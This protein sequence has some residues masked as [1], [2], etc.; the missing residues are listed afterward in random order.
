MSRPPVNE[1]EEMIYT[2]LFFAWIAAAI[3][4]GVLTHN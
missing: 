1:R 2:F 4:F 3:L